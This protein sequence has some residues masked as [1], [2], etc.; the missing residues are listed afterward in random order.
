MRL[1][2]QVLRRP[3]DAARGH[4]GRR[5]TP[6]PRSSAGRSAS[7]PRSRRG[8]SRSCWRV[9]D[10]PGAAR[11]QH[12]GAQA[13]AVHAAQHARWSARS[14][15]R[16][17]RPACSTSCPAATSS[18]RW[19]TSHPTPR[20][21]SFTGSVATGK[22][23]AAAAAP[24]LKRVTLELGGNDPAIVLDDVDPGGDRREALLQ[25]AFANSGQICSAIKRVYVPEALHDEV[26]DALAAR[27]AAAKVGDG[28]E[29]D[30]ELGPINN[31][32]AV[33][34]GERPRRRGPRRRRHR[35]HRRRAGRRP[36]YFFEPTILTGVAEGTRIVD[37]E[38]F[39]PALPVIPYRDVDDAVARANATIFGL[40]GSVWSADLDR[41]GAVAEQLECG[42]AWVNA[43]VAL[44]PAPAL[45]RLQVERRR[46]GERP[47]GARRLHRDPGPVPG[48]GLTAMTDELTWAP[49]WRIREMIA[50][51]RLAGGGPRACPRTHRGAPAGAP[52][53]RPPGR[54]GGPGRR[55]RRPRRPVLAGENLRPLHGIP[56]AVKCHIDIAGRPGV[57]ALRHGRRQRD[58]PV[59][60]RLR[61]RRSD[62]HRPHDH[63]G[64]GAPTLLRLRGHRARTP[65]PRHD[66][67]HLERGH[68]A[69]VAAGLLPVAIGS[70]GG[71]SSRR[72]AAYSGRRSPPD[73]LAWSRG[74]PR[75]QTTSDTSTI[76]PVACAVR[77]AAKVLAAIAGP[78]GRDQAGLQVDLRDTGRELDDGRPASTWRG[79]TTSGSPSTTPSTRAPES[80]RHP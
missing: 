12:G 60:E 51:G 13:V 11:R 39:G 5:R 21:I 80:S 75:G 49:A 23:V 30:T 2:A 69:A 8:T 42:T 43:H 7:S 37:E 66:P 16:C 74:R 59:V 55:P 34:A 58:H 17:C 70:D 1:L 31:K 3:R 4:P 44:G 24:D 67:R 71:G 62:R 68:C 40:S 79:P 22:H 57:A 41:A 48:P 6:S 46:R 78:D 56:T 18:G 53:V 19:M 63:A 27:A 76:G 77:D 29:P 28:M 33:R 25:G 20:K 64:A 36:G 61:G 54:G 35:G 65:G 26:V 10:R 14:S 73:A 47:L 52:G 15:T 9:E 32:P 38:Q 72:P 45:R 50:R